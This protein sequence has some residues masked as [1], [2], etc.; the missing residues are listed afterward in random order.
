MSALLF[1]Q[2][3]RLCIVLVVLL[4]SAGVSWR[5]TTDDR[6]KW[7]TFAL[8]VLL[9][10]LMALN[11]MIQTEKEQMHAFLFGMISDIKKQRLA[12]LVP[13]LSTS[14]Q[15]E[16]V[17]FSYLREKLEGPLGKWKLV[18]LEVTKWHY[19][20]LDPQHIDLSFTCKGRIM[21]ATYPQTLEPSTWRLR[22]HRP[23]RTAKW[24]ITQINPIEVTL[25]QRAPRILRFK[26]M[27]DQ[28][29]SSVTF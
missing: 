25:P 15:H 27:L 1:E 6:L 16:E 14:Y 7:A 11:V 12:G 24:L 18:Q 8:G 13:H 4:V 3:V 9:P 19:K 17:S 2:P 10:L 23:P 20:R 29:R 26:Q 28:S 21:L 5:I 22:L